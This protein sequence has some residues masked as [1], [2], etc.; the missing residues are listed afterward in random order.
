MGTKFYWSKRN[1]HLCAKL[2]ITYRKYPT[3]PYWSSTNLRHFSIAENI[4]KY[5]QSNTLPHNITTH[6]TEF[7]VSF[8]RHNNNI[9]SPPNTQIHMSPQ[10]PN[11]QQSYT[12]IASVLRNHFGRW[13]R[14]QRY[15]VIASA[16]LR[17]ELNEILVGIKR[18]KAERVCCLWGLQAISRRFCL[19]V[20]VGM[21]FV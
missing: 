14:E 17:W 16:S 6:T 21:H 1:V 9:S 8:W 18:S 12:E 2:T 7:T 4:S 10:R 5:D 13:K 3:L 19:L 15:F 20:R 11:Q